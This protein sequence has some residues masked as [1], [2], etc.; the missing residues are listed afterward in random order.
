MAQSRI[1]TLALCGGEPFLFDGIIDLIEYA[2]NRNIKCSITTNG[3]NAFSLNQHEI[4][5]LKKYNTNI[6]ISIDS[7]DENI[8]TLTRGT[9]GSL[10]NVLKS[11]RKLVGEGIAITILTTISKYNYQSLFANVVKA[12]KE[13][14]HE[15]LFQPVIT[16]SNYPDRLTIKDKAE[17]NVSAEN[18]D[19]LLDEL[20]NII[21]YEQNRNIRTNVYRLLT[22]IKYY[23]SFSSS[24]DKKWFFEDILKNFYCRDIFAIIDITYNGGIQPCGLSLA[25]YNI[26][27]NREYGL[28]KMWEQ[29]TNGIKKDIG[30]GKYYSICNGCCHHFSRNMIASVM[31]YPI[32][33]RKAI[34]LLLPQLL[35]R[36]LYTMLKNI[37]YK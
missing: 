18:S 32:K 21:K 19:K 34:F 4:N 1:R 8:Q 11:I 14:V 29:A 27:E 25:K 3:M 23:I 16:S 30:N 36:I 20:I 5:V 26:H 12:E 13:G 9:I 15:V 31:K 22:W 6:N 7:F 2:G 24:K 28:V 33:N 35:N 10:E 17:L 37:R